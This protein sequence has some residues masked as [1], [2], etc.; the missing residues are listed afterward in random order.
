M[1]PAEPLPL[2]QV[3]IQ[4]QIEL[5]VL[6]GLREQTV[7]TPLEVAHR[8][9]G[10][11][12]SRLD[13]ADLPTGRAHRVPERQNVHLIATCPMQAGQQA[14]ALWV[15]F[16]IKIHLIW[17]QA[18]H[19]RHFQLHLADPVIAWQFCRQLQDPGHHLVCSQGHGN[20]LTRPDTHPT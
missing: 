10:C 16:K 1:S 13:A 14:L 4:R 8:P 7:K 12:P 6:R 9:V 15:G 5:P 18:Q 20:L 19:L 11:G 17:R 3:L 2:A